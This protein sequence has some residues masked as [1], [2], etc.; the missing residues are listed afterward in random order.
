METEVEV[1][2]VKGVKDLKSDIHDE[3]LM[4]TWTDSV[5]LA[6]TGVAM[7]AA[8]VAR[9]WLQ[10]VRSKDIAPAPRP[11]RPRPVV[12]AGS[13]TDLCG[14]LTEG[15]S[16]LSEATPKAHFAQVEME[17]ERRDLSEDWGFRWCQGKKR[18]ILESLEEKSLASAWNERQKE[19]GLKSLEPRSTLLEANGSDQKLIIK[20]E[21]DEALRLHLIFL[22]PEAVQKSS[23][24]L[25][26]KIKNSFLEVTAVDSHDE[27]RNF[28]DPGPVMKA[29]SSSAPEGLQTEAVAGYVTESEAVSELIGT[30]ALITGLVTSSEF[31]GKFCRIEA[32]DPQVRRYVVRVYADEGP[33]NAKL[34]LENLILQSALPAFSLPCNL[35][36]ASSLY[37]DVVDAYSPWT[38]PS[39]TFDPMSWGF[40]EEPI[41]G[42]PYVP[43]ELPLEGT[44]AAGKLTQRAICC[45]CDLW[46][47]TP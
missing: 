43:S 26:C 35:Q 7:P 24:K 30:T 14:S 27:R 28:S 15:E 47:W 22:L 32:F 40:M 41:G 38:W 10:M 1:K 2:D 46:I 25:E 9:A 12:R 19:L 11:S 42:W 33:V 5:M 18:W 36:G 4:K 20:Q 3:E 37:S 16:D 44:Q 45:W 21:L 34:R 23:R 6:D 39:P 13:S 17:L 31:N 8:Q 29:T